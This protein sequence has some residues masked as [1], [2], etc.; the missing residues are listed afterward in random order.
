MTK[1]M[2]IALDAARKLGPEERAELAELLFDTIDDS[3]EID[4]AWRDE[5]E[6]RYQNH[7]RSGQIALDAFD[8][9]DEARRL[10]RAKQ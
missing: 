1:E 3:H 7:Q 6:L 10:L 2:Q 4:A 8:A 9:V 5:V